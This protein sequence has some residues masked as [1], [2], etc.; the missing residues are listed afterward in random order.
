MKLILA[1][2]LL[3]G[4]AQASV[5]EIVTR[6]RH[7]EHEEQSADVPAAAAADLTLLKHA[8]RDLITQTVAQSGGATVE[9]LQAQVIARLESEDVP[10]GDEGSFGVIASITLAKPKECAEWL[11][12]RVSLA[13]P[14]GDDTSLYVYRASKDSWWLIM[15]IESLGYD[16]VFGAPGWL[17]YRV[18]RAPQTGELLL[19][20]TDVTPSPV[21][22]WQ[23]LRLKV[24]RVGT[25]PDRPVR[26]LSRTLGYCIEEPYELALYP[27]GFELLYLG[28]AVPP[29]VPGFRGIHY[30]AY[31]IH[32]RGPAL[33][34]EMGIDP[35]TV[36]MRWAGRELRAPESSETREWHRRFRDPKWDC[37]TGDSRMAVRSEFGT[38][39]LF[40]VAPCGQTATTPPAAYMVLRASVQGLRVVS[41]SAKLPEWLEEPSNFTVRFPGVEGVTEPVAMATVEPRLP[42]DYSGTLRKVR[43]S[44]IVKADG[45]LDYISTEWPDRPGLVIPAIRAVRQWKFKPGTKD[46]QPVNVT[47][48]VDVV[49]TK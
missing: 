44:F 11:V 49:F 13:I 30:L 3:R 24:W 1:V 31:A 15:T 10:V 5:W 26:L 34:R 45:S 2:L 14:Y 48:T 9:T 40:A 16:K 8:L 17:Q 6:L 36:A 33:I 38:E 39:Q 28:E 7:V 46:D 20:T 37:G 35:E 19:I 21:S 41:V 29:Q 32:N 23:G 12:A 42:A 22:V 18:A 43:V 27:G 47:K 25:R 4:L